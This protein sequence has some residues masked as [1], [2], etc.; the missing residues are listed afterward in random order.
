MVYDVY[1][2]KIGNIFIVLQ[3]N[4]V[5][6]VIIGDKNWKEFTQKLNHIERD[7]VKCKDAIIQLEEYFQGNRKIFTIPLD[8]QGTKFQKKVWNAL[9]SIPYGETTSY[10]D[11][12]KKIEN[13]RAI[14]AVGQAN[15][16]NKI[17]IFIPCHRVINKN[18]NIGG[19]MGERNG[20]N[21]DFKKFLIDLE[22]KNKI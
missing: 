10:S 15:K 18:G 6:N 19:Y 16:V 3:E 17:P 2:S 12:A 4:C 7:L 22:M 13:P 20:K 8:I 1:C 9:L 11:I 5:S 21:I 14:Q